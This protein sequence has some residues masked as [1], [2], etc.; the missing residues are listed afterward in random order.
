MP[1]C[2]EFL[3]T[4]TISS[5]LTCVFCAHASGNQLDSI[6]TPTFQKSRPAFFKTTLSL[7]I[8]KKNNSN[9]YYPTLALP[10]TFPCSFEKPLAV[11]QKPGIKQGMYCTQKNSKRRRRT[12]IQLK[13][14][15]FWSKMSA[16]LQRTQSPRTCLL[17]YRAIDVH[18]SAPALLKLGTSNITESLLQ[19]GYCFMKLIVIMTI[20]DR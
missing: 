20:G 12:C 19:I 2:L 13:I 16:V 3:G 5:S 14:L 15:C 8:H 10:V 11:N 1:S 18:T 4:S 7:T 9:C 17:L 6:R